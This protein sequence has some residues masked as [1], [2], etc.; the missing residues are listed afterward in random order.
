MCQSNGYL[1]VTNFNKFNVTRSLLRL[2]TTFKDFLMDALT[3]PETKRTISDAGGSLVS[4]KA[5]ENEPSKL[6]DPLSKN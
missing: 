5:A 4:H 6:L 2:L 3:D 1:I